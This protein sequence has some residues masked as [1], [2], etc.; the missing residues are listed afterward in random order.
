MKVPHALHEGSWPFDQPKNC[1]AITMR[2]VLARTEPI[3]LVSHDADDHGW[4]FIG[5]TDANVG[6][7]RV[8]SLAEIMQLDP[9]VLEI[10]DLPPGWQAVRTKIGGPWTR[11][12]RRGTS[13][14]EAD[15]HS[16]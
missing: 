10:A 13:N 5:S 15:L 7:G 16:R 3:L 8:V 14:N 9:T 11:R 6:D 12:L 4:Q 2:Q 1:A